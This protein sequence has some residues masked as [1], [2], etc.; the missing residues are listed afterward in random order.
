MI[1]WVV[2]AAQVAV[3]VAASAIAISAF[4]ISVLQVDFGLVWVTVVLYCD[5]FGHRL[6]DV[7]LCC[8]ANDKQAVSH[9]GQSLLTVV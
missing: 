6:N 2:Q 5:T 9:M 4:F 7:I 8:F 1:V 3:A